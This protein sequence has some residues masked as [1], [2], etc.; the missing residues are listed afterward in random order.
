GQRLPLDLTLEVLEE[1]VDPDQFYRAN[2]QFI[3]GFESISELHPYFKGR[4][5]VVLDP[6]NEL[7]LVVSADKT[8]QFKAWLD[9]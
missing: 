2:R 6:A 5:K 3:V 4:I 1:Q 8:R 9:K 7:E